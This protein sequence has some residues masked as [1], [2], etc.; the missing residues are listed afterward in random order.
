[1]EQ[2]DSSEEVMK[3]DINLKTLNGGKAVT[4]RHAELVKSI[5]GKNDMNTANK[6]GNAKNKKTSASEQPSMVSLSHLDLPLCSLLG[7][8]SWPRHDPTMP[9][10]W[11]DCCKDHLGCG[12]L[13]VT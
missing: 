2:P 4:R 3:G 8:I 10:S 13:E 6:K 12:L 7:A 9:S 11:R 1:M 5:E